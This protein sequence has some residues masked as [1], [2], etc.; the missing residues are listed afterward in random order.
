MSNISLKNL[1]LNKASNFK[2]NTNSHINNLKKDIAPRLVAVM[3]AG[4]SLASLAS[5]DEISNEQR[6]DL[7]NEACSVEVVEGVCL[8]DIVS[9]EDSYNYLNRINQLYPYGAVPYNFLKE[10]GLLSEKADGTR[11]LNEESSYL[12]QYS[13]MV[14]ENSDENDVYIFL[15]YKHQGKEPED[16]YT[17]TWK[18]KYILEDNDYQNLLFLGSNEYGDVRMSAFIDL[19]DKKYSPKIEAKYIQNS[20]L[21][22]DAKD[23]AL[24]A[25]NKSSGY[26][27][28]YNPE[29]GDIKVRF[30]SQYHNYAKELIYYSNVKKGGFWNVVLNREGYTEEEL[31]KTTFTNFETPLGQGYFMSIK[32][33][34]ISLGSLH[35]VDGPLDAISSITCEPYEE[36]AEYKLLNLPYGNTPI[37]Q[38]DG[39]YTKSLEEL[40]NRY[41]EEK[42]K[43]AIVYPEDK[44]IQPQELETSN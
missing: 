33:G 11:Y 5:C 23:W 35:Y 17:C 21:N 22:S 25:G 16:K 1:I 24:T 10:Q 2:Q 34:V 37:S 29:T 38:G 41:L 36:V 15:D 3:L 28:D 12:G 9:S 18:L 42:E 32:T 6:G 30:L 44:R 27:E 43:Y 39:N 31:L 8:A 26:I 13:I 19:M 20:Y 14:D 4:A 7:Y 40:N